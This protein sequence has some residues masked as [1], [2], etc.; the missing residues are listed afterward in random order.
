[1]GKSFGLIGKAVLLVTGMSD[2][3][4]LCNNGSEAGQIVPHV[5]FH[6]IPRR[7]KDGLFKPWPAGSYPEGE[8][9]K[10]ADRIRQ[11]IDLEGSCT[12]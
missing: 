1:M 11:A 4:L 12:P 3:N 8:I 5:H 7:R 2:Y 9:D 10:M 6:I